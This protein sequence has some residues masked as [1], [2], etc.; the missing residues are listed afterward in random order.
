MKKQLFACILFSLAFLFSCSDENLPSDSL[1]NGK[2]LAKVQNTNNRIGMAEAMSQ[3][4]RAIDFLDKE[5]P[6][7]SKLSRTVNSVSILYFGEIKSSMMKSGKYD[8]LDISDTLAYVFNFEDSL[9]FVIISN[10]KRIENPLLAFTKKGSLVNGE[11]DNPGLMIFLERLEGY[12][13]ESIA[14]SGSKTEEQRAIDV[15]QRWIYSGPPLDTVVRPL[16]PVEWGQGKPFN[17]AVGGQC[18]NSTGN[19]KYWAGCIATAVAQIMSYWEYPATLGGN[20]YSWALLN[21]YK[22]GSDFEPSPTDNAMD[23]L[24]KKLARY[25]VADLFQ[26][27]GTGVKMDY[28]CDGSGATSANTLAFLK[29]KGFA[30][31]GNLIYNLAFARLYL[32]AHLPLMATGC[33][34]NYAKGNKCHAWVIDGLA[35]DSN[36][37]SYYIHNNWGW[38]D[39]HGNGYYPSGAFDPAFHNFQNVQFFAVSK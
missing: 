10:D 29:S 8:A 18:N 16:V 30:L 37:N 39:S 1:S 32:Q 6:L 24:M 33:D 19:N 31:S 7:E 5:H 20:S 3:V 25:D 12:V 15:A 2:Y 13:L 35:I 14:K 22:H 9:G 11:T 26:R 28:G 17:S 36:S 23:K 34:L 21:H 27:I 4:E 38:G